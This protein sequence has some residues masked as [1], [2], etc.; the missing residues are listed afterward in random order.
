MLRGVAA[1]CVVYF[2]L[3]ELFWKDNTFVAKPLYLHPITLTSKPLFIYLTAWLGHNYIELGD[4]GVGLFFLISGF[5]IPF[6]L[7]KVGP[8]KFLVRRCFRIYPTYIVAMTFTL[9]VLAFNSRINQIPFTLTLS[10]YLANAALLFDVFPHPRIGG[11]NWTLV[12][13]MRFY[14][15][16]ALICCFSNLR[17]VWPLLLCALLLCL[18]CQFVTRAPDLLANVGLLSFA[19]VVNDHAPYLI[20]ML[21]G[22]CF[23]N[24]FE[25][26]WSVWLFTLMVGLLL[27]LF[28]LSAST[29][30]Y[31]QWVL[32][33]T[34]SYTLALVVFGLFYC[35]RNSLKPHPVL[36]F[37][38]E[39]S[40]P[41]YLIH[42]HPGVSLLTY[43]YNL[44]SFSLL[45]VLETLLVIIP[46][47]YLLHVYVEVPSNRFGH[48]LTQKWSRSPI[49]S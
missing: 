37:F 39:I 19:T 11:V 23:H 14:L 16:C 6:S 7:T 18:S 13:E 43:L 29:I 9:L 5:V 22:V 26:C 44:H 31:H 45:N 47:S 8:V 2:H 38:A 30:S 48:S 42:S 36:D 21:I 28:Y 34:R 12:I 17:R 32:R 10:D 27:V 25:T 46:L 4:F 49:R 15:I 1:L 20:F 33:L 3:G 41:L 40:F 35:Y 24:L